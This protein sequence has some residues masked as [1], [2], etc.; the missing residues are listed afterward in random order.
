MDPEHDI[1]RYLRNRQKEID[2]AALYRALS[3]AET[4]PE[5]KE[6]YERLAKAE[7]KHAAFW[8]EKLDEAGRSIPERKPSWRARCLAWLGKRFGPRFVLPT[9]AGLEKAD[10]Q[11]YGSQPEEA[12]S[13]MS[14]DEQSHARLIMAAAHGSSAGMTGSAVAQMEGRHKSAG[15]NALRAAVLGAN[16]GLVSNLSLVMGVAGASLSGDGVL[17]TGLAGLLAGAGSMA[18]GEWL[19][20]QSSRE[21]YELQIQIEKEELEAR[22]DEEEEELAL[23]YQSKGV[24]KE[25]AAELAAHIIAGGDSALNTLAREELGIDPDELGGSAWEAAITSFFL[26]AAGAVVPVIPFIFSADS[27]AVIAS[28][29]LSAVGLFVIGAA[30]T[31]MTGRNAPYSGMRMVL[32]GMTAAGL[33][34]GIGRLIGVSIG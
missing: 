34:Y 18:L 24:P 12:A 7:E 27:T 33:T 28:V 3:E 32:F 29:G 20:V 26:F 10:S 8:E 6:V 5:M 9:V 14:A 25:R 21:L 1:Q 2:G 17:I 19:S 31:L 23:I 13:L 4:K 11:A 16:D 15:G 22:P 30:I